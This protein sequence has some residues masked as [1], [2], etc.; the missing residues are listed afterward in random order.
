MVSGSLLGSSD[1]HLNEE[2]TGVIS[3]ETFTNLIDDKNS[4]IDHLPVVCEINKP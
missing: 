2:A 3:T 4:I 1:W